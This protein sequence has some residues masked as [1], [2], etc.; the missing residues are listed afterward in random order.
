MSITL[1]F[2]IGYKP[3]FKHG[4]HDQSSHGSWAT[5]NFDEE[6][7]GED[8]QSTYFDTYGMKFSDRGILGTNMEPVGISREEI[9]AIDFY[10]GDGFKD[11]NAFWRDGKNETTPNNTSQQVEF[12]Q[13]E[14][15]SSDLD[16]L[17]D[18]SPEMFGDKNLF[19]VYSENVMNQIKEGDVVTD[20]GYLSTTRIDIT[21]S[22]NRDDL[23]NLQIISESAD[24]PAVILPSPSGKGK[25]L[26]VDYLKNAVEAFVRNIATANREKE[27]LLPR[28][29]PLKFMGYKEVEDLKVA[30]FQ[31]MDK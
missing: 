4:E 22:S 28:S 13:I 18:E 20:K 27:I 12:E 31:R 6:T 3:V 11:I 7:E 19:R 5:G 24:I 30:V 25:G 8:S 9:S 21:K 10:T 15:L 17:I 29:T 23:E 14:T 16:K 26:A 2:P 1:T